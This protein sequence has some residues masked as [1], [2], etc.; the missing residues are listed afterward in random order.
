MLS[1]SFHVL[2]IILSAPTIQ[3]FTTENAPQEENPPPGLYGAGAVGADLAASLCSFA[4]RL[5]FRLLALRGLGRTSLPL[6][7]STEGS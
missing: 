1:K 4:L 7:P 5:M 3:E 2:I 6:L